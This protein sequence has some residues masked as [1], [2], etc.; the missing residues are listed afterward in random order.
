M[1]AQKYPNV[2][3]VRTYFRHARRKEGLAELAH[4][5]LHRLC[6]HRTVED[7]VNSRTR[8]GDRDIRSTYVGNLFPL[9]C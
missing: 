7:A 3:C 4:S 9:L 5:A 1:M 8:P 6:S 2:E